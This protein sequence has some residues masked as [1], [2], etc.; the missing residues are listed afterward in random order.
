MAAHIPDV[1]ER[2]DP[3]PPNLSIDLFASASHLYTSPTSPDEKQA[4]SSKF[5][6]PRHT[7]ETTVAR[8]DGLVLGRYGGIADDTSVPYTS[9]WRITSSMRR[10]P[11]NFERELI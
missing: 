4:H 11:T 6:S 9:S 2:R 5:N 3:A 7:R 10:K 8:Y 1:S